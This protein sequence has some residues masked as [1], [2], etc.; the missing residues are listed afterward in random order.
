MPRC[1]VSMNK[2]QL[3]A[4]I[5]T[6]VQKP[7]MRTRSANPNT[8]TA[9]M[10][11]CTHTNRLKNNRQEYRL[12]VG[13]SSALC[14]RV[15]VHGIVC[16]NL[17]AHRSLVSSRAAQIQANKWWLY[18]WRDHNTAAHKSSSTRLKCSCRLYQLNRLRI[19]RI[20]KK[21]R[22]SSCISF[23]YTFLT[24]RCLCFFCW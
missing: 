10:S 17:C 14:V 1:C 18:V 5:C 21:I 15:Y 7:Y 22:L 6:H 23:A 24:F 13:M 12:Y 19:F 3:G 9:D 16:K 4:Q 11:V 20:A 8:R 2:R